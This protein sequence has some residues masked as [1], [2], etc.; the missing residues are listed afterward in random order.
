[1][2]SFSWKKVTGWSG[3]AFA[4]V[5]V[6][7]SAFV[8]DSP[9]LGDPATEVRRWLDS[10]E[11]AIA[12]TTWGGGLSLGFLF[13]LF[14][15]GLRG[16]LAPSDEDH[17]GVWTRLSFAGAVTMAGLGLAKA[18]FWAVLSLD[19]IRSATSDGTVKALAAFDGVAVGA[20]VPWAAAT[21]LLGASVVILH[22]HVMPRWLG[23]LGI[24]ATVAF[25]VGTLWIFTGDIEGPLAALTL[26]GYTGFLVFSVGAAISLIRSPNPLDS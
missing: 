16:H 8:A 4:V 7:S 25:V 17:A 3:I 12:W 23:W 21:F 10:H 18:A 1:M 6:V 15:S 22:S 5:F 24:L 13:L 2:A 11:A 19:E 9:S 14:A 26:V 20:L